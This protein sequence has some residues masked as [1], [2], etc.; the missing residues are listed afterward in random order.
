MEDDKKVSKSELI[1]LRPVM[2]KH[3]LLSKPRY[4]HHS[5][6]SV[7]NPGGEAVVRAAETPEER[8]QRRLCEHS[9]QRSPDEPKPWKK[10]WDK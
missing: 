1:R 2:S 10:P 9:Y 7:A 5:P 3:P 8:R 6:V 4:N